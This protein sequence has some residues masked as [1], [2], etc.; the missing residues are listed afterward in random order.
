MLLWC[1]PTG[2]QK[3][4]AHLQ[5]A[6]AELRSVRDEET[7]LLQRR[8]DLCCCELEDQIAELER[9]FRQQVQRDLSGTCYTPIMLPMLMMLQCNAAVVPI[10]CAIGWVSSLDFTC[11]VAVTFAAH[12]LAYN[13]RRWLEKPV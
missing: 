10:K 12:D 8:V 3:L 2:A 6:L 1:C 7:A 4:S 9:S 5:D 11:Y 13:R